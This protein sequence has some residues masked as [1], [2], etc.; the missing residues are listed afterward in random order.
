[1]SS[2]M[3]PDEPAL[4]ATRRRR[5][6]RRG[7]A[8]AAL[9]ALVGVGV[10]H[11]VK[12]LQ[13]GV[14]VQG[15]WFDTAAGD[16][17]F[18]RDVT[19]ADAY[20]QPILQ[21]QIFDEALRIIENAREFIVLDFFLFNAD[22][23]A[24]S[25]PPPRALSSELRDALLRARRETPSMRVLFIT[26]P[27]ND[28]YGGQPSDDLAMLRAA[29]IDVVATD[30]DRL[31]D[32]NAAYSAL[33]RVLIR[34]WSGDGRGTGWLPNPLDSGPSAVTF[35]AWARLLNFKANHRKVVIADD[36]AGQLV[37]IVASGNP[38]D[39]SSAHSNVA[40][41]VAGEA[42]A[43]LLASELA[44][45]TFSGGRRAA[46]DLA[47]VAQARR[48][49]SARVDSAAATGGVRLRVLTEGGIRDAVL[50]QLGATSVGDEIDLAMFYLA[51][52]GVLIALRDAARRGAQV[53]VLLDPNKDA[54]GRTKSGIPNR[55]V[56][57][58]LVTASDSAIHVRWYRTH[59]E[60]FHTKLLA[61]HGR[62]R[63][64]MTLGSANFT[65]RNIEDYNLEANLALESAPG[66]PIAEE[67]RDWFEM[68]WRNR[69]A[70]G[71]EYTA[72]YA[73]YADSAQSRYWAYRLME[74]TGLSTF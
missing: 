29:G 17:R 12:P 16:A 31:R 34:W 51:D 25:N 32:P 62:D 13:P 44:V 60:Q 58:E 11:T 41:R 70:A 40:L 74:A 63:F 46:D 73:V 45:A 65:R 4:A 39:A 10:W 28:V 66:S 6:A 56:A 24:G 50:A 64:W 22:R 5:W 15:A 3:P 57:S 23:G 19:T 37:G 35:R 36:G 72:D 14:H 43:P 53:R 7:V 42:L 59:G 2:V 49:T 48:A 20:G 38:H 30:L 33:W 26:D 55:P 68:L 67:V 61:I 1:M 54:F 71:I 9:A 18:L 8:L 27:I 52:R 21:Q 69:A 47:R